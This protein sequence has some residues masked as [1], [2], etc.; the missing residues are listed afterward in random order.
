MAK[1]IKVKRFDERKSGGAL[2]RKPVVIIIVIVALLVGFT[3]AKVLTPKSEKIL[4]S[5]NSPINEIK[6]EFSAKKT[7]GVVPVGFEHSPSGAIAAGSSYVGVAPRLY[8]LKDSA[9][10]KAIS[11]FSASNYKEDLK[12]VINKTRTAAQSVF[13]TDPQAFFREIP[14][15]YSVVSLDNDTLTM[16]I[17]T[18]V[19]LVASP[20]L[21]G[22]TESKLHTL[23]VKWENDD[24][25]ISE[26]S[27]GSG[28]TPRWQSPSDQIKTV[29]EFKELIATFDKGYDY[30][31]NN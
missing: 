19:M 6:G 21:N 8:L 5:S 3:S 30:V 18:V 7:V 10:N 25:K 15:S 9:F 12:K 20:D 17:W 11:Q 28:P 23:T 26:W 4:I 14:L 1:T 2:E 31:P 27:V 24:W 29:D 16:Q 22:N 13:E